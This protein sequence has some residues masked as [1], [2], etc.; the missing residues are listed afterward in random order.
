[1][2]IFLGKEVAKKFKAH[3]TKHYCTSIKL[4]IMLC[5]IRSSIEQIHQDFIC[6]TSVF[7]N[8][9]FF[10]LF[11]SDNNLNSDEHIL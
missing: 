9:V 5:I 2:D 7:D 3:L 1:M 10:Y 4:H 11:S 8:S 6:K